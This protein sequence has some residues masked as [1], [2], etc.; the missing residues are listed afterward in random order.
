MYAPVQGSANQT[1]G[2]CSL[3]RSD[4]PKEWAVRRLLTYSSE[5]KGTR[6]RGCYQALALEWIGSTCLVVSSCEVGR[7]IGEGLSTYWD[8]CL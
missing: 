4:D 6:V 1:A 3:R 7:N 2:L 8:M 5:H